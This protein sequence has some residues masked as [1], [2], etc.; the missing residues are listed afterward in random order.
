LLFIK[1]QAYLGIYYQKYDFISLNR[2]NYVAGNLL[3]LLTPYDVYVQKRKPTHPGAILRDD[4]FPT[5]NITF[6]EFAKDFE[7]TTQELKDLLAEKIPIS[8]ILATKIGALSGNGPDLWL[9]MQ[10]NFDSWDGH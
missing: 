1:L 10:S 3:Q 5:L 9:K 4:V 2:P 6:D 8:S 7:V